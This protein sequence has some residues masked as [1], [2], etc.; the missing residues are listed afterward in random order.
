[1]GIEALKGHGPVACKVLDFGTM[2]VPNATA[3]LAA[4]LR[5][6]ITDINTA[7]TPVTS[8]SNHN[9]YLLINPGT[10]ADSGSSYQWNVASAPSSLMQWYSGPNT[11]IS[12]SRDIYWGIR[13]A[14]S[15]V[16]AWD[17]KFFVGIGITDAAI[18]TSS[19]GAFDGLADGIG[20][21]VGET[22]ILRLVSASTATGVTAA[23][24]TPVYLGTG[25]I[26]HVAATP[27]LDNTYFHDFFFHAHWENA[28]ATSASCF[29]EAYYDGKYAGKVSGASVLPDITSVSLF[30]TI[31]VLNGPANDCHMAVASLLNAS[32]RYHIA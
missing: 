25:N 3:M 17:S 16:T 26:T 13:M 18:M 12:A 9:G 21:H 7:T 31:E 6:T 28:A 10:K 23:T 14:L 32:P 15:T 11:T 4:P 5:V 30:N 20:F 2:G 27:L 1:M 8:C 19:T 22:G 24:L 29:V